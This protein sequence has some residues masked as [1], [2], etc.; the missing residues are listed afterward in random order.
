[1]SESNIRSALRA[2]RSL[3]DS[4]RFVSIAGGIRR[5]VVHPLVVK[6]VRMR[7]TVSGVYCSRQ[8]GQ[9]GESLEGVF[10]AMV[11]QQLAHNTCPVRR[12]RVFYFFETMKIFTSEN[13]PQGIAWGRQWGP[14]SSAHTSQ[15]EPA[16]SVSIGPAVKVPSREREK[17]LSQAVGRRVTTPS[18][19]VHCFFGHLSRHSVTVPCTLSSS[20][21]HISSIRA[22]LL[23]PVGAWMF[24]RRPFPPALCLGGFNPPTDL[25]R[26]FET[27]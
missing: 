9:T 6:S 1:V 10:S 25:S 21:F 14:Y 13:L 20:S 2:Q 18:I 15:Y 24:L 23:P 5:G 16:A 17:K 12:K 11:L 3:A 4:L 7:R 19:Y 8:K 22:S 26:T 27:F